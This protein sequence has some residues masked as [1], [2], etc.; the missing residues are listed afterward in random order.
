MTNQEREE[1][2]DFFLSI[3][4]GQFER[5][6]IN[7]EEYCE[8]IIVLHEWSEVEYHKEQRRFSQWQVAKAA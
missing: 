1:A 8:A 5:G 6:E 4:D 7:A 2:V 3:F